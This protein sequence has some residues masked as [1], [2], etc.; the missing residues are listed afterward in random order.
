VLRFIPA[1]D[2]KKWKKEKFSQVF[3]ITTQH[4][5]RFWVIMELS[6]DL[7]SEIF[8]LKFTGLLIC[9]GTQQKQSQMFNGNGCLSSTLKVYHKLYSKDHIFYLP[10]VYKCTCIHKSLWMRVDRINWKIHLTIFR[11]LRL[12]EMIIKLFNMMEDI[13]QSI[14]CMTKKWES[15]KKTNLRK[16][17]IEGQKMKTVQ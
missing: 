2:F 15:N 11:V 7:W 1:W 14:E 3:G 10:C 6:G 17:W 4:S 9:P 16:S 8:V 12:L 5:Y 13:K